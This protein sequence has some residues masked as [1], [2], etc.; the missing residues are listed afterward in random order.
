MTRGHVVRTDGPYSGLSRRFSASTFVL[1]GLM[2]VLWASVGGVVVVVVGLA[3]AAVLS[4]IFAF[5]RLQAAALI[6]T[7][8]AAVTGGSAPFAVIRLQTL[9]GRV[10]AGGHGPEHGN[11][12]QP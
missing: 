12:G 6:I 2:Y 3:L 5:D 11:P 8:L 1:T 10:R 4:G 7:T 9:L